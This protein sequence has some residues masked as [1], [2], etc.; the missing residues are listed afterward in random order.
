MIL[1]KKKN[2][3]IRNIYLQCY[4]WRIHCLEM[5]TITSKD[6]PICIE[7]Y[8]GPESDSILLEQWIIEYKN[9]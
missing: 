1:K 8:L 5:D 2:N 3:K 4:H 6:E 9:K 7:V